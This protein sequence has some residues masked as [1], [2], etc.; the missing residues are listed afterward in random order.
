M[1]IYAP[2]VTRPGSVCD[3]PVISTDF[4]PTL[5]QL[6][7]LPLKPEQHRDGVSIVPMLEGKP[8]KCG[9]PLF[10]HYPHYSNQ[11]VL[12]TGRSATAM[13]N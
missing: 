10:W 9:K 5:L 3:T 6:A 8:M 2:G 12:R 1:I 11:G 7:G 13:G 4:Y